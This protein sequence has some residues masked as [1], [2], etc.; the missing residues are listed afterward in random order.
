[1]LLKGTFSQSKEVLGIARVEMSLSFVV[2]VAIHP[3]Y[4]ASTDMSRV[5]ARSVRPP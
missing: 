2:V 3:Y 5:N 4:A 1:M